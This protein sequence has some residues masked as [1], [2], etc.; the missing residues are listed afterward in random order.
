L[1]ARKK[2]FRTGF[3]KSH[4]KVQVG[5]LSPEVAANESTRL[6][7]IQLPKFRSAAIINNIVLLLPVLQ[8]SE[9]ELAKL[10]TKVKI[11]P[12]VA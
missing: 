12:G 5:V 1:S 2:K 4:R 10:K 8:V 11:K 9:R 7:S 6:L 3:E